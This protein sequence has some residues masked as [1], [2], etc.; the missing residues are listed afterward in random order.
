MGIVAKQSILNTIYTYLGFVFG[1]LNTLF[2][3]TYILPKEEFGLVT[4]L[5]T[6]ANLLWP[7]LVLGT[8]NTLTK[9]Y[10]TLDSIET[11][12]RFFS[13]L[14]VLPLLL[15]GLLITAYLFAFENIQHYFL[16]SN[17]IVAPYV[18]SIIVLG[19][20]NAYFELFFTWTK[21]HLQSVKGNFIKTIFL[22]IA[23]SLLLIGVYLK[24]FNFTQFIYALC[25]ASL[26]RCIIML[27]IAY[28]TQ[29]FRFIL[30]KVSPIQPMVTYSLLILVASIVSVYLLDLDKVMIEYYRPIGELASYSITIYMASVIAVPT[31]ALLQITTPL[32]AKF[33][34]NKDFDDLDNLNKKSSL[35]GFIISG[36]V[37]LLILTNAQSIFELVPKNYELY[38]EIVLYIA[39]VRVFDASLGITN[40][41]LLNSESYKWVLVLGVGILALAFALN[42]FYIP[43]L[44]ITGA[45]LATFIAYIVF[46]SIKL[47]FVFFTYGIQPY[48][49]KSIGIILLLAFLGAI[50]Y[51][52]EFP[53]L[54]A[55]LSIVIKGT[56]TS[57]VFII[58]IYKLR[59]S[60]DINAAVNKILKR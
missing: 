32:T 10:Y 3:F 39:I 9:F 17:S 46:N 16:N 29:P 37:A 35:N 42:I 49:N 52:I 2:L 24:L 60:G 56:L 21:V 54:P 43:S 31:R 34:A 8:N 50:F 51:L 13:W 47:L 30:K 5:L 7:V 14:L 26:L 45:A 57:L 55:L 22:R 4:Y 11:Q 18:W 33:L 23:L 1:A 40:S 20:L 36:F 15:T 38:F 27:L 48:Q 59:F 44:G 6:T 12:N 28:K 19:L 58:S 41:I 25:L 53:S